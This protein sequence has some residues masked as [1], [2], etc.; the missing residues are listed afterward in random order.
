MSRLYER[1]A[2]KG[3]ET[4]KLPV[5]TEHVGCVITATAAAGFKGIGFTTNVEAK[6]TQPVAVFLT[7][8]L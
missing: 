4:E 1:E 5:T 2:P 6:D 7:I 8:M 3:E